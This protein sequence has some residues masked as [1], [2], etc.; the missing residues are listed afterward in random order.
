M[1]TG[2]LEL[3]KEQLCRACDGT[4]CLTDE[5]GIQSDDICP[6]CCGSGKLEDECEQAS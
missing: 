5:N 6:E 4:G 1:T 3:M 2:L